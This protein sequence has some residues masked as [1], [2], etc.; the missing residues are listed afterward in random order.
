MGERTFYQRWVTLSGSNA[1]DQVIQ[2][3]ADWLDGV[4]K[5]VVVLSA[6][7]QARTN[8]T[9]T[10]ETADAQCGP[11]ATSATVNATGVTFIQADENATNPLQR[12]LRWK[13]A[14]S[15]V[16]WEICFWLAVELKD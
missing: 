1:S 8:C 16:N 4:D 6:Q 10:I 9:L 14:A 7:V 3:H 12:Y 13:V 15:D 11:W 5:K 2:E